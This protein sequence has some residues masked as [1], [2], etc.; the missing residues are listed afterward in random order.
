MWV[1]ISVLLIVISLI[2]IPYLG[3]AMPLNGSD[4]LKS[5]N[6]SDF[7]TNKH[8][9]FYGLN[10]VK[11][12]SNIN[13]KG[14]TQNCGQ[15]ENDEIL[16]FD[17]NSG[18]WFTDN[19]FW[20]YFLKENSIDNKC[21][22]SQ[23]NINNPYL[24]NHKYQ[25]IN[26]IV[27][28]QI[29]IDS[30]MENPVPKHKLDYYYNFFYGN[31]SDKWRFNVP[32]YSEILY[33]NIYQ[34]IDLRYYKDGNDIK[35]DLLVHPGA[36][37]KQIRIKYDG[38]E[39]IDI[40]NSNDLILRTKIGDFFDNDLF[41]YQNIDGFKNEVD[42]RF[43]KYNNQ[44]YGFEML[45]E[46]DY[47]KTLIIDPK[48]NFSTFLGGS[49]NDEG[50]AI[51]NDNSQNVIIT[52]STFSIDFPTKTGSV[53]EIYN[54]K[55]D[56]FITKLA[57][58]GSSIIYS[59]FIGGTENEVGYEVAID[60][61]DYSYITG[62]TSSSDF[63]TTLGANDT[64]YNGGG[65]DAF[66]LRL[67]PSGNELNYSTFIGGIGLE[68]AQ[69]IE[70][71][72]EQNAYI[73]GYTYSTDFPITASAYDTS[74]NNQADVFILKL[75]T[76]GS[77]ILYST[78]IGGSNFDFGYD[79]TLDPLNNILVTGRT[80]STNF[81]TSKDAYCSSLKGKYDVFV[82][83]LNTSKNNL[84]FSTYIGGTN[85]EK[86]NA[87]KVDSNGNIL[88]TG[89]TASSDFPIS[90]KTYDSTF[91]GGVYDIFLFKLNSNG[92]KLLYSTFIGGNNYDYCYDME[93]DPFGN[94]YLIGNSGS[95]DFPTTPNAY[96]SVSNLTEVII[97]KLAN[98]GSQLFYSTFIGGIGHDYGRGITMDPKGDIYLTGYTY[99]SDFPT[100]TGVY[101]NSHSGA[102]D[103][104]IFK[105]T[106]PPIFNI[107]SVEL[108]KD[109]K[110][111]DQIYS[112]L[113]PYTFRIQLINTISQ[114]D[115]Q[116][117]GLTLDPNG[118]NIE[119][120]WE[121][122]TNQFSK[123]N[124]L[125]DYVILQP[126]S[127]AYYTFNYWTIEFDLIFNWSYPDEELHDIQ[128]Y[129]SSASLSPAWL[130]VTNFYQVENDLTFNGVLKVIG[131]DGR[132][133]INNDIVR[134]GEILTWTD[135]AVVY[136]GTI[137]IYP[138][139]E[140]FNIEI[141]DEHGNLWQDSPNSGE[142][143]TIQL[144]T[145]NVT[146]LDGEL[147][148]ISIIDI[149]PE[150]VSTSID[151]VI[152]I[153]GDNVTFTDPYPKDTIWQTSS[154]VNVK[155]NITDYGGGLVNGSTIMYST[156]NNNG[157]NWNLWTEI[158]DIQS[159][160]SIIVSKSIDFEER[161]DN[162]I[163]WKAVDSLGNGPKESDSYGIQVD[164]K[165]VEFS[166]AW[167]KH[168]E[169][170]KS[171]NVNLGI[172]ILDTTS[173][174]NL[175]TIEYSISKDKGKTWNKWN[176]VKLEGLFDGIKKA[177]I[178]IN[179][180]F[181]NGTNNVL[182]WRASDMAG[183]DPIESP[184]TIINVNN[185][186]PTVKPEVTLQSPLNGIKISNTSI[187]LSWVPDDPKM[188]D[189]LYDIYFQSITPPKIFIENITNTSLIID[190][191]QNGE[192]YYW[193]VIPK[194]NNVKG[195]CA[196]GLWWFVVDIPQDEI[197][198]KISIAGINLISLYQ[199]EEK[200]ITLIITNLGTNK[201]NIELNVKSGKLSDFLS[202]DNHSNLGLN[203]NTYDQRILKI[204][205]SNETQPG[206]YEIVITATSLNSRGKIKETHII[207][208]EIK[209]KEIEQN[210][211][212]PNGPQ[213]NETPQNPGDFKYDLILFSI[214]IIIIIIILVVFFIIL[215]KKKQKETLPV[216]SV[217]TKPIPAHVINI[218]GSPN[219]IK[220][221]QISRL[222]SP[223]SSISKE[224]DDV[225]KIPKS[226]RVGL[227]PTQM[228]KPTKTPQLPPA[229]T[230]QQNSTTKKISN[231]PTLAIPQ[232]TLVS[233]SVDSKLTT[234]KQ[235][236][237]IQNST[238][239]NNLDNK[240]NKR[241][242]VH[243]PDSIKQKNDN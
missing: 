94:S 128:I 148:S 87:I 63:P 131:E 118:I 223:T 111:V 78:F 142:N 160:N 193:K 42:G 60:T 50:L 17:L 91:N 218:G 200:N 176:K 66:V 127:K 183:N 213:I 7:V 20:F 130:N 93:I 75:S 197:I 143:F 227:P 138:H 210:G 207:T 15:L 58:N 10:E 137:D 202:L 53:D 70:L 103:A 89:H 228:P 199:D 1:K 22:N 146:D 174:I 179:L 6:T 236:D 84:T 235:E 151:F 155:I 72:K 81:P 129:S 16:F 165:G 189:I 110:V 51:I 3:I 35:Y 135:L 86:G 48:L 29:F 162:L 242:T 13:H 67:S 73:T 140:E 229:Q 5:N 77:K 220:S 112:C 14:F 25:S 180:T 169:V 212:K 209:E 198:F 192:T 76:N 226:P 216:G 2:L 141:N 102:K 219:T 177:D 221:P 133:L 101:N 45:D 149:P 11:K 231:T 115:L 170:S 139:N 55:S 36:D 97:I 71:D 239:S 92:T 85:N 157:S 164:T 44:E 109:E 46:Y 204:Q 52:G 173:G 34:D 211:N 153:D 188:N 122:N 47:D 69:G 64:S 23:T 230:I 243:L 99:S 40:L 134:G 12:Y 38:V 31:S 171:E 24:E 37:L 215:K 27:L 184:P 240:N 178:I 163:R 56:V 144:R 88:V 30:D 32:N 117:I 96:D 217:T 82:V 158:N 175:S 79:I 168:N 181:P 201:D 116:N 238:Q 33:K 186:E 125:N 156:S 8:T 28:K 106:F 206:T 225:Q 105:L 62:Y 49:G 65:Y 190:N 120:K 196:S 83:M 241:P 191:L 114:S 90:A 187:E 80:D 237:S 182:K 208:I 57:G 121:Q 107:T 100:T 222:P 124:D 113:C 232:P 119:L 41:I 195:K 136:D 126:S 205:L 18:A 214:L 203:S 68:Y 166:S 19:G 95:M 9:S 150:C 26:A 234:S 98:N 39:E 43:I 172:T 54:G 145:E 104:F 108:I 123:N 132:I 167:P 154:N 61:A 21:K 194:L 74:Y 159:K 224:N 147:Y 152:R 4:D 233:T 59:T 161:E 185:W